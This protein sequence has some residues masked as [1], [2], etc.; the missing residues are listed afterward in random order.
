MVVAM[1][2]NRCVAFHNV[3]TVCADNS[4]TVCYVLQV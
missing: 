3:F 2:M 1:V 4:V